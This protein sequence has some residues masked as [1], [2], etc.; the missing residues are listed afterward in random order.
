M[1]GGVVGFG[2]VVYIDG[3]RLNPDPRKCS[4]SNDDV[5][6]TCDFD[7]YYAN[8]YGEACPWSKADQQRGES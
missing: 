5:C 7:R 3:H 4:H 1:S 8:K 2:G 6:P